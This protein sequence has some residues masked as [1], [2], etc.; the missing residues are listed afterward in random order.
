M[1][2]PLSEVVTLL[3]PTAAASKVVTGAGAWRVRRPEAGQTFYCAVVEGRCRLRIA[4]RPAVELAAGDFVLIPSA[5]RFAMSSAEP[6]P[7]GDVDD[8]PIA[9][10]DGVFRLGDRDGPATERLLI[11]H[12][13]FASSDADLL[14]P[15]LPGVVHVRGNQR[16]TTLVHLLGEEARQRRPARE[17]I[18]ARLLEVLLIEA[19]R[20]ADPTA[21]PGLVRGLT[22]PRLGAAI[23]CMHAHPDDAWTVTRLAQ[24]AA[25]SRSAFFEHFTRAVG[26]APMAYLQAWRMALAKHVL[27]TETV[28]VAEVAE[29]VGYGSASAFSVAFARH[30]GQPP[31]RYRQAGL[32]RE[33]VLPDALRFEAGQR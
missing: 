31:A 2:D 33:T 28:S 10:A 1:N 17:V 24:A 11:G 14:V 18:L 20:A 7:P 3:R 32:S 26:I 21:G 9:L 22:D 4:E 8:V 25:L 19:L 12:C 15:L 13:V 16:L 6:E 30:V 23:R 5:Q 27:R 29:R